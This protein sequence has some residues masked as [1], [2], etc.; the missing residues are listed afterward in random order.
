MKRSITAAVVIIW[1][2]GAWAE[3]DKLSI[4]DAK[5][6]SQEQLK[7]RICRDMTKRNFYVDSANSFLTHTDMVVTFNG[8]KFVNRS[9]AAFYYAWL[10]ELKRANTCHEAVKSNTETYS[11]LYESA[12]PGCEAPRVAER[13]ELMR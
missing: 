4:V 2:S 9:D 3:C 6:L 1:A 11:D 13:L 8:F 12:T 5:A 10:A 7:T